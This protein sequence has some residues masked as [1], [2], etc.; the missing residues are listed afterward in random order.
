[1]TDTFVDFK[2]VF[3]AYDG[4]GDFAVEDITLSTR[5]GEF[6]AIVG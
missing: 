1:M 2:N 3:L 6:I 5:Q 4:S